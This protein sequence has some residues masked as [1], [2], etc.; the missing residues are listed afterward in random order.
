[1]QGLTCGGDE[2]RK[3]CEVP[4]FGQLVVATGKIMKE[5][6]S[7]LVYHGSRFSLSDVTL[8]NEAPPAGVSRTKTPIRP[9]R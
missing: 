9:S 4:A 5:T 3:C 1:L 2:S 8:C 6:E 7:N